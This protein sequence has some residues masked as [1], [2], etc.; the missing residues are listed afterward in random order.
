MIFCIFIQDMRWKKI[1]VKYKSCMF[2]KLVVF[3][4]IFFCFEI[5]IIY[6]SQKVCWIH[7]ISCVPTNIACNCFAWQCTDYILRV[8]RNIWHN[9]YCMHY[10]PPALFWT[11]CVLSNRHRISWAKKVLI[12]SDLKKLEIGWLWNHVKIFSLP[13]FFYSMPDPDFKL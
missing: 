9:N 7:L 2:W 6:N 8:I 4:M 11:L 13:L 3:F 10:Y 1:A 5:L 12:H